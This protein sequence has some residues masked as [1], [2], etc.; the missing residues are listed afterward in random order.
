MLLILCCSNALANTKITLLIIGD[1]LSA[2]FGIDPK[3]GWVNLLR[4]RLHQN[5][6]PVEVINASISGDTTSNGLDRLPSALE[7]YHPMLTIIE[8]GGNDGLRGLQIT[9]IK[10]NL[11]KMITLTRNTKSKVLLLGVR[12]PPNY[13]K[14]Y[15]QQFQQIFL[16]LAQKNVIAVQPFF[17][18]HID[19]NPQLMQKDGLHPTAAAQIIL[20]N[21]V[22]PELEKLLLDS[23]QPKLK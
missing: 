22:W 15:T 17:L 7:N 4:E 1:S 12:L 5:N 6:Y 11:Q 18:N 13:G 14:E 9:L 10:N 2:G 8:L 3:L 21:N 16:D 23:N 20:L 19:D